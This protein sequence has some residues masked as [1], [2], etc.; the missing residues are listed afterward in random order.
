MHGPWLITFRALSGQIRRLERRRDEPVG[1]ATFAPGL[2]PVASNAVLCLDGTTVG[3]E[4]TR[5]V[6]GCPGVW[7]GMP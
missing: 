4:P 1:P 5:M 3:L 2:E 7:A 6:Q